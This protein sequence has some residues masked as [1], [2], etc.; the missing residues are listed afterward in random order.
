[1]KSISFDNPLL[2]LVFIPMLL[3]TVIPYVIAIRRGSRDRA[4][5]ISLVLHLVISAIL[6]L[7]LAGLSTTTVITETNVFVVAD[8]S[9]SSQNSLDRI[10]GYIDEIEDSLP[11]NSKLGVVCF[12]KNQVVHTPLGDTI[13]SVKNATDVDSS[14]T[15][16]ASALDYTAKLFG[17]GVIKKIV[18]ITD[19]KATDN[20]GA[21]KLINAIESLYA[22]GISVD[23][24]YL[25]NNLGE[26]AKEIQVSG[27]EF[28]ENTYLSRESVASILLQSSF[29]TQVIAE[30]YKDGVL[31]SQRA[32][33]VS[34]GYNVVSFPLSTDKEG[35][36]DYTVRV[37]AEE[38]ESPLNNEYAFTQEISGKVKV[39]LISSEEGDEQKV[40]QMY[41]NDAEIVSYINNPNIPATVEELCQYDEIILSSV[42]IRSLKNVTSFLDA[43]HKAVFNF[44]KSLLTAGDLSLQNK[45]NDDL[46]TLEDMLP[47]SYGNND[48]EPKLYTIIID[49]SRSMQMASRLIMTKATATKL[50][51][52][53]SPNDHICIISFSGDVVVKQAP[54]PATNKGALVDMINAIEPSQGTFIGK[55]LLVAHELM[56]DLPYRNKQVMLISDGMSYSLESDNPTDVAS[57]MLKDGIR[58]STVNPRSA[59]GAD[60]LKNIAAYGG[61]KC[62]QIEDEDRIAEFV[63]DQIADDIT[64]TVIEEYS[65]VRIDAPKHSTVAGIPSM[66]AVMGYV[67]STGKPTSTTVLSVKYP[68]KEV[69]SPLYSTWDY[70][71]GSVSCFTGAISGDW[72]TQWDGNEYAA[73]FL[74]AVASSITPERRVDI[75]YSL[76]VSYDGISARV[77]IIPATLNPNATVSITVTRPDGNTETK[78]LTFDSSKYFTDFTTNAVGKYTVD[79]SYDT[80]K[81]VYT[82]R[83]VV[84]VPYSPEYDKFALFDASSLFSAI[85]DRGTVVE[86]GVPTLENDKSRLATYTVSFAL[87]FMIVAIVLYVIDIIV[88]KLK[89]RD[90]VTLFNKIKAK[91]GKAA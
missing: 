17:E 51:D 65:P 14:A 1:M 12:A 5:K 24:I 10:D 41:G 11:R 77:E 29:D 78:R 61:G 3:L 47:I 45:T 87:P 8:V 32:I 55:S 43:L 30:L 22:Q 40:K 80:G 27:V 82:T 58:V 59:E 66:P 2:L 35:V 50:L 31:H 38:D 90:I 6:T 75:P 13:S 46:V 81:E 68:A 34:Q 67:Y 19:G 15:D 52:Y 84:N 76:D 42:D 79:I 16:I 21:I 71:E 36:Y 91:G 60:T 49:S 56:K 26:G 37:R 54:I 44:G 83:G 33:N 85:R 4:P 39:L 48:N 86:E 89:W 74:G 70:G 23:A 88:R 73:Q 28:T 63:N 9:H 62:Y 53:I 69:Y 57:K 18:L 64:E 20:D 72:S 7:A 25:D